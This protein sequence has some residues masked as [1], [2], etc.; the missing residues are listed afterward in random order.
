MERCP[1]YVALQSKRMNQRQLSRN[2]LEMLD[3]G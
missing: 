1:T 3:G 2:K